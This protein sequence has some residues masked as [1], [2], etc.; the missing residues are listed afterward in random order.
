MEAALAVLN[1]M[2]EKGLVQR[3]AIGGALAA[4]FY[5]EAVVTEDL[6][7]F[8][9][10]ASPGGDII[11]LAPVYDFLKARGAVEHREHLLLEGVLMQIIPA[12][13]P[14]TEEAVRDACH[15]VVGKTPARVMTAEHLIAIAVKTGR[16]KDHARVALLLEETEVDRCKL[17]GIL[18]RHGLLGAWSRLRGSVG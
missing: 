11:S 8:V 4:L 10:L 15:R 13:D 18:S 2:E 1:E 3:S 5:S 9:L 6:D 12:F 16:A 17:E 14:L 7:V